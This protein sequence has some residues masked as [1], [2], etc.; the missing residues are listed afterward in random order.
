MTIASK[1]DFLDEIYIIT[2]ENKSASRLAT[3]ALTHFVVAD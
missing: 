2:A 3:I 1:E